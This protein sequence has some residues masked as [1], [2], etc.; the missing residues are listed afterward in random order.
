LFGELSLGLRFEEMVNETGIL[1]EG[2]RRVWRRQRVL[3]WFF[4]V[5]LGLSY[6]AAMPLKLRIASLTSHS[7]A[8][9]RLVEG[10]DIGAFSELIRN[11]EVA[12]GAR[13]AESL[14]SLL[15]FFVFALFLTGG[16]LASY[17]ADYKLTTAEFFQACG[18]YFWRWVRLLALMIIVLVPVG[19]VSYGLLSWSGKLMLDAAGEKTGY[20]ALLGSLFLISF[21]AMTVRLWFDVAQVRTVVEEERA[22]RRSFVQGL[23]LSFSH[24]GSLFWLYLRISLLAWVGLALGLWLTAHIPGSRSGLSF[25]VLE[26]VLL[27]WAAT[28]LWQRASEVV[29]YQRRVVTLPPVSATQTAI[30]GLDTTPLDTLP[31]N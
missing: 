13:T 8:A 17:L 15:V 5:N 28:R 18:A 20:W 6:A 29:W 11:P 31:T 16:I 27:W 10:F 21:L 4:L 22:I 19:F 9:S 24:F 12:F 1:R 3:W 23:K 2:A 7:L 30:P 26:I 14:P 25:F